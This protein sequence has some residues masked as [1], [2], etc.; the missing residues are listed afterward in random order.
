MPAYRVLFTITFE[1]MGDDGA[2]EAITLKGE[3]T[4][5][6]NMGSAEDA[7]EW[8]EE[9]FMNGDE[10]ELSGMSGELEG[11]GGAEFWIWEEGFD[12][13]LEITDTKLIE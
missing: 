1:P 6:N 12:T 3:Q 7:G 8:L 5:P 4:S 10:T 9:M 2:H 11:V 13:I